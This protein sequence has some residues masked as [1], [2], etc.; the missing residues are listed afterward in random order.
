MFVNRYKTKIKNFSY[1]Y[2]GECDDEC[3]LKNSD[4]INKHNLSIEVIIFV[5]YCHSLNKN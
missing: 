1:I 3:S 2:V 5:A 4:H